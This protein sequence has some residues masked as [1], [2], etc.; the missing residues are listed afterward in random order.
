MKRLSKIL[1][2]LILVFSLFCL[3]GRFGGVAYA[4]DEDE[5]APTI[6]T[7]ITTRHMTNGYIDSGLFS[8]LCRIVANETGASGVDR[9]PLD[10]F[11]DKTVLDLSL[12]NMQETYGYDMRSHK[13]AS[14]EG[15]EYLSLTNL[16]TLIIDNQN[17]NIITADELSSTINTLTTL[18]AQGNNLSTIDVTNLTVL[19]YL[20]LNNNSL[21]TIDLSKMVSKASVAPTCELVNNNISKVSDIKLSN[22]NKTNLYLSNNK[23]Y[24]AKATDF[25]FLDETGNIVKAGNVDQYHNVS[26]LYQGY[27]TNTKLVSNN[28][29]VAIPD[30]TYTDFAVELWSVGTNP[31]RVATS[32]ET[33]GG[34]RSNRVVLITGVYTLKF[35][36]N[37][38]PIELADDSIYANLFKDQ[39]ITVYPAAPTFKVFVNGEETSETRIK[40]GFEVTAYADNTDTKL[41]VRVGDGEWHENNTVTISSRG[42]Y[43]VKAKVV[44]GSGADEI[45]SDEASIYVECTSTANFTWVIIILVVLVGVIAAGVFLFFWFRNGA[46]VAPIQSRDRGSRRYRR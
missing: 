7:G 29:L 26:L 37:G 38:L 22:F 17:V 15:L 8:A 33:V 2:C 5:N 21:T 3:M 41:Y 23:L 9:I 10:Y 34:V 43:T 39:E 14:L 19:N 18:S 16:E 32:R 6:E 31:E 42:S 20:K 28:Y 12:K 24:T 40:T 36:N 25:P 11:K 35:T 13:I 4:A 1:T 27:K 30:G 46:Q 45:S 44:Y